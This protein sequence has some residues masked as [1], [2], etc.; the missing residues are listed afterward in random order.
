MT[1]PDW[2][3]TLHLGC[4]EESSSDDRAVCK[5][6]KNVAR[7]ERAKHREEQKQKAQ[8]LAKELQELLQLAPSVVEQLIDE[9]VIEETS[10]LGTAEIEIGK[11]Y[12]KNGSTTQQKSCTE[13]T[14]ATKIRALEELLHLSE[15]LVTSLSNQLRASAVP[16]W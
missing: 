15:L 6:V 3:P 12:I 13:C 1:N 9:V 10:V 8:L 5:A 7:Y 4:R 14:C 16:F 2:L 11:Q